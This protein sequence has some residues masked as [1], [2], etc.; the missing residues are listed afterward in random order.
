MACAARRR[1]RR[2]DALGAV[3]VRYEVAVDPAHWPGWGRLEPVPADGEPGDT[4]RVD[5]CASGTWRHWS[6]R[7]DAAAWRRV[8]YGMKRGACA[9]DALRSLDGLTRGARGAAG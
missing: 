6:F 9:P 2:V 8:G 1:R 4:V 5:A 7:H 3:R